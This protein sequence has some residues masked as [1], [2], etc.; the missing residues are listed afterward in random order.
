MPR[1][2]GL[3]ALPAEPVEL[4]ALATCA[5]SAVLPRLPKPGGVV[6]QRD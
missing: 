5:C 6:R 2:P 4:P 1:W 3:A